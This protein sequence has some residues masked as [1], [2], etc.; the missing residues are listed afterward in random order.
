[1]TF[2]FSNS[3]TYENFINHFVSHLEFCFQLNEHWT[4]DILAGDEGNMVKWFTTINA[5]PSVLH[6]LCD[7]GNEFYFN[8]LNYRYMNFCKDSLIN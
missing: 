4:Q 8:A 6:T 1:M 3:W 7:V 2:E 5:Y